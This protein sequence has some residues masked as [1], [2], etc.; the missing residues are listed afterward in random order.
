M[1]GPSRQRHRHGEPPLL[2]KGGGSPARDHGVTRTYGAAAGAT[3]PSRAAA[4]LG[5]VAVAGRGV[6]GC[7]AALG[8]APTE[9]TGRGGG[10]TFG[11]DHH[12]Q[13]GTRC[14]FRVRR[15]WESEQASDHEL[16]K[17]PAWSHRGGLLTFDLQV[18]LPPAAGRPRWSR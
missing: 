3:R 17:P 15:F 10:Q 12:H 14:P 5:L 7:E 2:V 6:A 8:E 11:A 4:F 1:R 16:S 18:G 9:A 13:M